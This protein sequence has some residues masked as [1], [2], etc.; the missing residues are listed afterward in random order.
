[1]ASKAT[2]IETAI[3]LLSSFIS[4]ALTFGAAVSLAAPK[5]SPWGAAYF[6]N[7][8]LIDQDGHK[9]KF[10]DDVIKGKTVAINFIYTH[11]GDSCPAETAS[12]KRVQ[13][14]LG[15]R[16]GKDIFFYSISIDPEHDTPRVLKEYAE[17]FKVGKGWRFLTGSAQ[18]TTL[19]RKKLGL[20]RPDVAEKKLSEHNISF[21]LGNENTGQWLKK[22]PFD[23]PRTLVRLLGYTLSSGTTAN[24]GGKIVGYSQAKQMPKLTRAEDIY[25]Y[26]CLSCHSLGKDDGIGPGLHGVT[27]RRDRKWLARWIKE[28]DLMLKEE[29]PIAVDLL[30]R[31]DKVLMPNLRLTDADVEALI[32]FLATYNVKHK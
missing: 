22:T 10:Y 6:P 8:E 4:V 26:R 19:L 3:K 25:R 31:Y 2:L 18:D 15:G 28:P 7:V 1:M 29:D 32:N 21:I 17:R 30:S 13:S 16:V 11:C 23:E 20:Y 27:E 9:L 5:D 24:L 14:L 12:L